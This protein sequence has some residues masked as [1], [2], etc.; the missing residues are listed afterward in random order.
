MPLCPCGS[1][2]E[3]KFCCELLIKNKKKP[4][5]ALELMKSRFSAYAKKKPK[6]IVKTTHP[7]NRSLYPEE[8]ILDW[9]ENCK[10]FELEIL[11]HRERESDAFV[12]FIAYYRDGYGL[13]HEHHEYSLFKK[14]GQLWY[15][16]EGE[17]REDEKPL[18]SSEE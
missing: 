8:E 4:S 9:M 14:I 1:E 17:V 10:F 15:F 16:E 11:S 18:I 3:Y 2:K 13:P 6:Y 7:D 5:S 12:E